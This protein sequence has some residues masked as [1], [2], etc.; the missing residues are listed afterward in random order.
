[1]PRRKLDPLPSTAFH[2]LLALAGGE[3]HGYGIMREVADDTDNKVR[4]GPGT[5]YGSIQTLLD[6]GYVEEI[7]ERA[8][9][10]AGDERRRYYRLSGAGRGAV[11]AEAERLASL[12]KLA[13][14][15]KVLKGAHV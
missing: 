5:L 6:A 13:K 8:V 10:S 3:K 7:A 1:M 15:K 12:L 11:R 9:A 4:L 2:I 14:S